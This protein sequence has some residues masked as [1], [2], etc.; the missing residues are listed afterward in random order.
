MIP[1]RFE[2]DRQLALDYARTLGDAAAGAILT[3]GRVKRAEQARVLARFY[4][5]MVDASL[6]EDIEPELENLHNAFSA[7]C[8][9]AGFIEIW[10]AEI[11]GD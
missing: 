10:H 9:Q 5:A 11:P 6:E 8:Y 3:A 7:G 4:W 1:F 2:A